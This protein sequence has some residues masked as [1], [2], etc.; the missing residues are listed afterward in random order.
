MKDSRCTAAR[1]PR[2]AINDLATHSSLSAIFC[3]DESA[4]RS[5]GVLPQ[6]LVISGPEPS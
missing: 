2:S 3:T 1:R 5:S 4:R 6:V